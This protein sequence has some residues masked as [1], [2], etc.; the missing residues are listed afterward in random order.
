MQLFVFGEDHPDPNIIVL[1]GRDWVWNLDKRE[2]APQEA[3]KMV[4][5]IERLRRKYLEGRIQEFR[6]VT[7]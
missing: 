5:K 6:E 7:Q 3:T 1:R 4:E 2:M